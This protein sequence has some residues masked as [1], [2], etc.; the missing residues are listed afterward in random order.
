MKL[1]VTTCPPFGSAANC[2]LGLHL[3]SADRFGAGRINDRCFDRNMKVLRQWDAHFLTP[4]A[5]AR[6]EEG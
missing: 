6:L 5:F 3:S 2:A 4:P 1:G